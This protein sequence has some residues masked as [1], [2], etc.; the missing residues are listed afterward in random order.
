MAIDKQRVRCD[1]PGSAHVMHLNAAG[2]A[3]PT[4][5]TLGAV[6]EHLNLEAEIGGYEAAAR[7]RDRVDH[8]YTAAAE[9]LNCSPGE[10]AVIE[11]AT[12]AWDMAFYSLPWARG[13]RI[14][15]S[16][17]EYA[18]N[19]VAYLQIALRHG[20]EIAVV[21]SDESGRLSVSELE[22]LID[23]RA[24]LIT[25]THVPTNGGLVNPAEEI[26]RVA[27]DADVL[28]LLD[29]C[30]SLGQIPI[31][32]TKIGCD[33]LSGTGRKYLRGPRGTGILYVREDLAQ[34]LEPPFVD[35]FAATWVARDHYELRPDAR[36]FENW[37]TNYSG[38]IGLG[39]ALDYLL[40]LGIDDIWTEV[41]SL[42]A[43]LRARLEVIP[44][45]RVQ[46]IGVEKC[47]IVSFTKRGTDPRALVDRMREHRVNVWYSDVDS[48]RLDMERRELSEVVRASVHYYNTEHELERFCELLERDQGDR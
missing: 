9:L 25:V 42:A 21:P 18:S 31:D 13:D 37:E 39:V 19:Y 12:R 46:D 20:V 48:T 44:G 41:R 47:G 36:R 23:D 34:A 10:I 8:P 17:A 22:R 6:V 3:L 27:R 7:Q 43:F 16:M 29:A 14:L 40:E 38:K 5:F 4:S 28:Y 24:K 35:L 2:A 15:T 32:V 45:V 26:G 33:F 1:T 30:Q 11:N